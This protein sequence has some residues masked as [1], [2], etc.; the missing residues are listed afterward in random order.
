[1]DNNPRLPSCASIY[2]EGDAVPDQAPFTLI[3]S[4][5]QTAYKWVS[6]E[7]ARQSGVGEA[8]FVYDQ[9]NGQKIAAWH[10]E[11]LGSDLN[12]E[13]AT[14]MSNGANA[15][16]HHNHPSNGSFIDVD[17]LSLAGKNPHYPDIGALTEMWAHGN[18]GTRYRIQLLGS[19]NSDKVVQADK[20]LTKHRHTWTNACYGHQV[21]TDLG[22]RHLVC[23]CL[24]AKG[25]VTYDYNVW[26]LPDYQSRDF[27]YGWAGNGT[28]LTMHDA[29]PQACR[30]II[31]HWGA[32]F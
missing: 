26:A 12:P 5:D 21:F 22:W 28:R 15:V 25:Y 32:L 31:A 17:L 19:D 16:L 29:F 20:F 3:K 4:E 6:D 8:I 23:L 1:M 7:V 10:D 13:L 24:E 2:R 11:R 30:H 18:G 14:A 27:T 9:R